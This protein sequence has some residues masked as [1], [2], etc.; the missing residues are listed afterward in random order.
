[1]SQ[2]EE[3]KRAKERSKK[4]IRTHTKTSSSIRF[5]INELQGIVE[6]ELNV[7]MSFFLYVLIFSRSER[8]YSSV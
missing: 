2:R 4:K 8:L 1:M 6:R 7:R 3:T 5:T